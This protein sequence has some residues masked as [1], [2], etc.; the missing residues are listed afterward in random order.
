MNKT[1]L[2]KMIILCATAGMSSCIWLPPYTIYS[3]AYKG[4]DFSLLNNPSKVENWNIVIPLPK[5]HI[6]RNDY[7]YVYGAL[8]KKLRKKSEQ[9]I[10]VNRNGLRRSE[11]RTVYKISI[12]EKPDEK[13]DAD[14]SMKWQDYGDLSF[15]TVSTKSGE[16]SES[17]GTTRCFGM[18]I[19]F[20][21][22]TS[23]D[24]IYEIKSNG[25]PGIFDPRPMASLLTKLWMEGM[26][27]KDTTN[28]YTFQPRGNAPDSTL[29]NFE[30]DDEV[31][32]FL[33]YPLPPK[34]KTTSEP[35]VPPRS[36]GV[37]D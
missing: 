22:K 18:N 12:S 28:A 4:R 23:E 32:K 20:K 37:R 9:N 19:I 6:D 21:G 7:R 8:V 14:I 31:D 29:S 35:T 17:H 27:P 16:E 5:T 1:H 25:C 10:M 3:R 33:G 24:N 15:R 36:T 26:Y 34:V 30:T 13:A 11:K 2:K